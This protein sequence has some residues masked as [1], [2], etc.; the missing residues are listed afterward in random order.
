MRLFVELKKATRPARTLE[1]RTEEA[2][3][4]EAM[5]IPGSLL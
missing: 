3:V 5:P 1:R 2:R 4:A